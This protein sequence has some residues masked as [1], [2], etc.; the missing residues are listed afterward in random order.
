MG[1]VISLTKKVRVKTPT[2]LQMEAVECGAASLGIILAYYKRIVPLAEL[3]I[4]CGASRDGSKASNVLLAARR[5]GMLADGFKAEHLE[6]LSQV[7]PPYIVFWEFNHFLVVEGLSKNWVF[8]NDPAT[9]PRRIS[10]EEFD[11]GF[12]GVVLVMKPGPDF[13]KG[14]RKKSVLLAL[15]D[16]LQGSIGAILYCILAGFLLVQPGL[17]IPEFSQIFIDEIL[18]ENRT[19]WLRPLILGMIVTAIFQGLLILLRLR[20]LRKL[21]IKLAVGMS[22]RFLWHLLELPMQFYA[23]RYAGEVSNRLKLNNKVAEVLS[24]QLA[25]TVIDTVMILFYAAVMFAYDGILT[26]IGICFSAI[27]A[28]ALQWLARKRVDVNMRLEQDWGKV[29]GVSIAGLSSIETLKA[30]ALE[31]DFFSRWSGHYAKAVSAQQEFEVTNQMLGILPTLLSSL[32]SMSI[33]VVGGFRVMN[34]NLSVGMLVAFKSL[35]ASFQQPFD[36]LV[37]FGSTLQEL[38]GSLNRLDDVLENSLDVE[39][40]KR[41]WEDREESRTTPIAIAEETIAQ[42][43]IGKRSSVKLPEFKTQDLQG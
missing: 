29:A 31:S 35:M 25:T 17:A 1:Q 42:Q 28:L 4:E 10:W 39:L 33:L 11:K 32:T 34:G 41:K 27:N 22:S 14:G 5:Y 43:W 26:L 19:E 6:Q 18:V 12:T 8:I 15:I 9:G 21:R 16:R 30:S 3:R 7:P 20:Y 13:S 2:V 38:E 24:G 23:Q 36:T 37:Y 40:E